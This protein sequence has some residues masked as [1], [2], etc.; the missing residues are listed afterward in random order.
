MKRKTIAVRTWQVYAKECF[1]RFWVISNNNQHA[2]AM[3]FAVFVVY[4]LVRSW[5]CR[6]GECFG[7]MQAVASM[8]R[9]WAC[10][11]SAV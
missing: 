11:M 9:S 6:S 8:R 7:S 3:T 2:L 5:W 1:A 10:P 4:G